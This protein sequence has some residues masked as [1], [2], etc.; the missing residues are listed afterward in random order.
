MGHYNANTILQHIQYETINYGMA[1]THTRI[2]TYTQ[3]E[4]NTYIH[5]YTIHAR[6]GRIARFKLSPLTHKSKNQTIERINERIN[7]SVES[8]RK[9]IR[10]YEIKIEKNYL[11]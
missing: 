1:K 8:H 9:V 3:K 11:R 7:F 10:S 4:R 2:Q 5:T 6:I